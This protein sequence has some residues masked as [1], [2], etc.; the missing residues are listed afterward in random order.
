MSLTYQALE[1]G[2][3]QPCYSSNNCQAAVEWE[4]LEEHVGN[5]KRGLSSQDVL[6]VFKLQVCQRP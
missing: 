6:Q 4:S 1:S 5:K 2:F 3:H